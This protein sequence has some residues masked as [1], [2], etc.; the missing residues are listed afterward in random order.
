MKSLENL[1]KESVT[2]LHKNRLLLPL[3]RAELV[4]EILSQVNI[5]SQSKTELIETSKKRVGIN[6]QTEYDSW[7]SVRHLTEEDF[8][9]VSLSKAKINKYSHDNFAHKINNRFLE[10]KSELDVVVYSLFQIKDFFKA[11]ELFMRVFEG[12]SDFG[13]IA[14]KYSVGPEKKTRGIIGPIP[15]EKAP[16]KLRNFLRSDPVGQIQPPRKIDGY[17]TWKV[18]RVES[19][20]YAKL[21]DLMKDKMLADLFNDFIE[22]KAVSKNEE[23]LKQINND[24]KVSEIK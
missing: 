3:I 23:L 4:K 20:D 19:F 17:E 10:K 12:E 11:K 15:V 21:D 13:D 6:N 24:L 2:L 14:A 7:L 1:S 9:Y 5:E 18:I 22:S 16:V 8:E